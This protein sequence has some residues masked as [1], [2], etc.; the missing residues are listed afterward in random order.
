MSIRSHMALMFLVESLLTFVIWLACLAVILGPLFVIQEV[1]GKDLG[2]GPM[3][4]LIPG[5]VLGWWIGRRSRG[6][7]RG[8]RDVIPARCP[9]CRRPTAYAHGGRPLR[10]DCKMCLTSTSTGQLCG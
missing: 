1:N 5:V 2:I 9:V 3:L 6:L 8:F 10:Y 7:I 4:A